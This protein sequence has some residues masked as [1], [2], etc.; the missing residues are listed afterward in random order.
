MKLL[1]TLIVCY[2]FASFSLGAVEEASELRT[3]DVYIQTIG[4]S[5]PKLLAE[6]QY[7]Q[8][9]LQAS[10]TNY[11]PPEF[12]TDS[13]ILRLGVYDI[14]R[15]VWSTSTSV[16]SAKS[17]SQGYSPT[18][19]LSLDD[20]GAVLGV[21]CRSGKIDAGHTRDFGPKVKVVS[22]AKGKVPDLNRPVVLKEGKVEV[23]VA[24][25]TMIQK[26]TCPVVSIRQD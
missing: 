8:T 9:S 19:I 12:S 23:P 2:S 10:L 1:N 17:F 15:K 16:T 3:A 21:S 20:K 18:I 22:S 7:D 25:K 5:P 14:S 13:D 4:S 11:E 26:Y 24:E 6:V